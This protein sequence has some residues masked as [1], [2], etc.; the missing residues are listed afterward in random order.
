MQITKNIFKKENGKG[1]KGIF[2][3][4]SIGYLDISRPL[5]VALYSNFWNSFV[6]EFC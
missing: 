3:K 4:K 2:Q 5:C 6:L 1:E